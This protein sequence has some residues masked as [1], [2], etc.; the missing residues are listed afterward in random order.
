MAGVS[1]RQDQNALKY[2][3]IMEFRDFCYIYIIC[4]MNSNK[5]QTCLIG[6]VIPEIAVKILEF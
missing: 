4:E 5:L 2:L 6:L 3:K 1:R